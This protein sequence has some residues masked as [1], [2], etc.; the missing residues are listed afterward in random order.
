MQ[1]DYT[2][3]LALPN[4]NRTAQRCLTT[5]NELKE[6]AA[7]IEGRIAAAAA[8]ETYDQLINQLKETQAE[9]L[10]LSTGS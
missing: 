1:L 5:L 9:V 3:K 8:P 10:K 6:I 2:L 4:E 7:S